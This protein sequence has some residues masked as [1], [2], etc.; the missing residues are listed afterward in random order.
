MFKGVAARLNKG[1]RKKVLFLVARPLRRGGGA[2]G[3]GLSGRTTKKK[4]PFLRLP[5]YH[6]VDLEFVWTVH[7]TNYHPSVFDV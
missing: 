2:R 3:K 5:L 1:S 6:L 4:N 7:R